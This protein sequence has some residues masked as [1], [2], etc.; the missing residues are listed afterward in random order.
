MDPRNILIFRIGHLGDT[1]VA[2]PAFWAIRQRF[3]GSR[4]TLLTNIDL[5]NPQY[6]SP[7]SV[8]PAKGLFDAMIAYPTKLS[9]RGK[10]SALVKLVSELR[11][12]RFDAAIYLMPR[13]RTRKQIERDRTFF[14]VCG[15]RELLGSS[16]ILENR[17]DVPSPVPFAETTREARFL[18]D[19]LN[20]IGIQSDGEKTDLLLTEAEIGSA[21]SWIRASVAGFPESKL[22]AIAPGAKWRSKQWPEDNYAAV[23]SRILQ[24]HNVFPIVFG[25]EE[26]RSAGERMVVRW[27][28]GANAA[29]ALS[30]RESAAVLRECTFYLGNDTGTMHL[31]S[32][33]GT[34]CVALFA[35]IDWK[36]RWS[37]LGEK[38]RL[39]R[40]H[41]HCKG[42]DLDRCVNQNRC[43]EL[44]EK[45][46]VYE[47]CLTLL[48]G[49]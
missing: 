38:H 28:K 17:L 32:A 40:A 26:D 1:V 4:L 25:G 35:A 16:F 24:D 19:L 12:R 20:E 27:G 2:L 30:V 6:I 46:Q 49:N 7:A 42:C 5:K 22:I 36:G 10:A 23:V 3:P 31:A 9:G 29:G 39:L 13:Q 11:S 43:L 33:V 47:E 8:L 41:F 44:I 37:P 15:I 18:L 14:R 21:R 34:P 48:D 45:E